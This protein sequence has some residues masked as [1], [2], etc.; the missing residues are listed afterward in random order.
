MSVQKSQSGTSSTMG[1]VD[2]KTIARRLSVMEE[3]SVCRASS[4]IGVMLD[5]LVGV[6]LWMGARCNAKRRRL[7]TWRICN[8]SG[9]GTWRALQ[10]KPNRRVELRR[11]PHDIDHGSSA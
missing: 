7:L 8:P 4:R 9:L 2:A 5:G 6:V 3:G 11:C 1:G 10:T